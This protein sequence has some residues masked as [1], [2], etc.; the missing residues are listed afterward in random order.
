MRKNISNIPIPPIFLFFCIHLLQCLLFHVSLLI[1][2]S[3]SPCIS[4]SVS[5]APSHLSPSPWQPTLL[6]ITGFPPL[7]L[8]SLQSCFMATGFQWGA[9]VVAFEEEGGAGGQAGLELGFRRGAGF[10]EWRIP[11]WGQNVLKVRATHDGR[12][13]H[14][15]CVWTRVFVCGVECGGGGSPHPLSLRLGRWQELS[16]CVQKQKRKTQKLSSPVWNLAGK[17][18]KPLVCVSVYCIQLALI[19]TGLSHCRWERL[20]MQLFHVMCYV[21]CRKELFYTWLHQTEFMALLAELTTP[22]MSAIKG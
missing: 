10:W 2:Y 14:V 18:D 15:H 8:F 17:L 11:A 12:T 7:C 21:F 3:L 6:C 22:P 9:L 13:I 20:Q 19:P 4:P 1:C 5:V 16:V